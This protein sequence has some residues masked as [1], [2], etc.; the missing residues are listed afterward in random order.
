M[1]ILIVTIK[2][3]RIMSE[4]FKE[5]KE[6]EEEEEEEKEEGEELAFQFF[7]KHWINYSLFKR[8]YF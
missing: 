2:K 8:V 7:V 3:V 5:E 6:E 1:L 4:E